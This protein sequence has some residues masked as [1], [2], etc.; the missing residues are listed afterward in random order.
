MKLVFGI[1]ALAPGGVKKFMDACFRK[2]VETL[3]N[4]H[5]HKY[6]QTHIEINQN[7]HIK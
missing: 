5:K 2:K 7:S 3:L 6:S 4:S 1:V